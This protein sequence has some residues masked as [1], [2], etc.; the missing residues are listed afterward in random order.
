MK[1]TMPKVKQKSQ[2]SISVARKKEER[3]VLAA[4]QIPD[5]V[6]LLPGTFIYPFGKNRPG[7]FSDFQA[8]WKLWKHW[9]KT[10]MGDVIYLGNYRFWSVRPRPKL[11][12]WTA[13]SVGKKMHRQMYEAF[14]AGDLA[15]IQSDICSGL[16]TSLRARIGQRPS[17]TH[18]KWTLHKHLSQPRLVSYKCGLLPGADGRPVKVKDQQNGV[19]QA[20]IKIHSLQSLQHVRTSTYRDRGQLIRKETLVDSQGRELPAEEDP[21]AAARRNAKET[22]EYFVIQKVLRLSREGPWMVWGTAEE[23]SLE[24]LERETVRGK[25]KQKEEKEAAK[26]AVA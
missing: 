22:V 17:N 15:P 6:G 18:L 3:Q 13:S 1:A 7:W 12:F 2:P 8:R 24:K 11:H 10:R 5:D 21:D 25:R 26:G 19:V 20:I 23:T 16:L 9:A 14:A 4:G